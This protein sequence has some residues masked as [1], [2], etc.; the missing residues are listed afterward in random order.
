M[1]DILTFS[2][3]IILLQQQLHQSLLRHTF[4]NDKIL[5]EDVF[6]KIDE[7]RFLNFPV[8]FPCTIRIVCKLLREASSKNL[9]TTKIASSI[10]NPITFI[11]GLIVLVFEI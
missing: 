1:S 7:Y 9:S 8:P 6:L 11:S 3:R 2:K 5:H 10:F 4:L